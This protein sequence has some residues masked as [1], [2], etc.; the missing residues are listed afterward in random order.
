MLYGNRAAAHAAL[1]EHSAALSDAYLMAWYLK[2]E[3]A[4]A[5]PARPRLWLKCYYRRALALNALGLHRH[6]LAACASGISASAAGDEPQLRAQ[7]KRAE[8]AIAQLEQGADGGADAADESVGVRLKFR[9]TSGLDFDL[10]CSDGA[11]T[12]R[13]AR[14]LLLAESA[15][16]APKQPAEPSGGLLLTGLVLRGKR[17]D[18]DSAP[19]LLRA[20]SRS[21]AESRAGRRAGTTTRVVLLALTE[22]L[23]PATG[24]EGYGAHPDDIDAVQSTHS[25]LTRDEATRVLLRCRG[26]VV[27]ALKSVQA[28][29]RPVPQTRGEEEAAAADEL[30]LSVD[31]LELLVSAMARE[32]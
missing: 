13:F 6:A 18:A 27:D 9:G 17:L 10:P 29:A 15:G 3:D 30:R 8:G 7:Q 16:A 5:E 28:T 22:A 2:A 21:A 1:G 20:A 11:A 12:L 14:E 32:C 25:E 4:G 31:E 19:A 24:C 23:P 26:D